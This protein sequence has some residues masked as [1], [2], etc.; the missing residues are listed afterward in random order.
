M[1]NRVN[2]PFPN[3]LSGVRHGEVDGHFDEA[4]QNF[5]WFDV[6]FLANLQES[7]G[8]LTTIG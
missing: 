2:L 6:Q 3:I 1:S 8:V 4:I 7:F 5:R